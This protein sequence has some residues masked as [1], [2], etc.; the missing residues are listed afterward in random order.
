MRP[1]PALALALCLLVAGCAAPVTDEGTARTAHTPGEAPTTAAPT[2]TAPTDGTAARTATTARTTPEPRQRGPVQVRGLALP[3]GVQPGVLYERVVALRDLAPGNGTTVV[4]KRTPDPGTTD[5]AFSPGTSFAT[6]VGITP[7]ADE[8]GGD[9]DD[10]G[11]LRAAGVTR[12]TTVTLFVRNSSAASVESTLVHEYAHVLQAR[13]DA[14]RELGT[15][16]VTGNRQRVLRSVLEGAASYVESA[17]AR[18]Y[19]GAN[20]SVNATAWARAS[21][22]VKYGAGPYYYGER[23]VA[24]RVDSPANLSVVYENPPRTTEQLLHG[25]APDEEP[26]RPLSVGGAPDDRWH[27]TASTVKGE[28]FLRTTLDAGLGYDRARNAST[29]WGAD[30]LLTFADREGNATGYAWAVRW[31]DAGEADEYRAALRDY[32]AERGDATAGDRWRV[33]E[34]A[35][36]VA[37]TGDET[38]VLLTGAPAFVDGATVNGSDASVTVEP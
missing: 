3:D 32:L 1:V 7:P 27:W 38:V 36:R 8:G 30:R 28:M 6:V 31:D 34:Y 5:G 19:Y 14:F 24:G 4:V 15:A 10:G 18:T 11:G 9:G 22:R 21:P 16:E 29:G 12:G 20:T 13:S 23:Y 37:S 17:Y 33:G 2:A 35:F 26:M 25:Y